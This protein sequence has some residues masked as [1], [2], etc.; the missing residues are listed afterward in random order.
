VT[1]TVGEAATTEISHLTFNDED[2][3]QPLLEIQQ[4]YSGA[5][6]FVS[7]NLT[8]DFPEDIQIPFTAL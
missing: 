6:V 8:V 3:V 5:D 7:G 1:T 2:A 4:A